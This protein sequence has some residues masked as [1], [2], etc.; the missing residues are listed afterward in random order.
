MGGLLAASIDG[1]NS[2]FLHSHHQA[3][4]VNGPQGLESISIRIQS[5]L[6]Q[7]VLRPEDG[8]VIHR[9]CASDYPPL[10]SPP[11]SCVPSPIVSRLQLS[12]SPSLSPAPSSSL[13]HTLFPR[14]QGTLKIQPNNKDT[15]D[16]NNN[17]NNSII[18]VMLIMKKKGEK[19]EEKGRRN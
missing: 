19:T 9:T 2:L 5:H 14:I 8:S 17:R 11:L 13:P 16:G 4:Q 3:W 6:G 18:M 1:W 15:S 12:E 10:H 7:C